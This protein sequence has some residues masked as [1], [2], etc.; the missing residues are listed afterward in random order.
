MFQNFFV[1]DKL[2]RLFLEILFCLVYS[3]LNILFVRLLR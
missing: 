1:T 2:G 3:D